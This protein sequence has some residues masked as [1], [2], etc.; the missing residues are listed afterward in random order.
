MDL[1]TAHYTEDELLDFLLNDKDIPESYDSFLGGGL[2]TRRQAKK[3]LKKNLKD[4]YG[5]KWWM[6]GNYLKYRKDYK[7]Q[8]NQ[9]VKDAMT[10]YQIEKVETRQQKKDVKEEGDLR[11]EA[12]RDDANDAP[13]PTNTREIT[14]PISGGEP[15]DKKE[16]N[17]K[18]IMYG[19]IGLLVLIVGF[20]AVKKF[21]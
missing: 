15:T 2:L 12:M 11:R 3:D 5:S 10:N 4:K 16:K 8:K 19:A 14:K 6:P 18:M 21:M 17:K 1:Y 20:F 9:V 13:D 7:D